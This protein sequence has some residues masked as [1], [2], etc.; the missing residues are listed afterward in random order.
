MIEIVQSALTPV[1]N[2]PGIVEDMNQRLILGIDPCE[3][4]NLRKICI[5]YQHW[6]DFIIVPCFSTSRIFECLEYRL[7]TIGY[8]LK[9]MKDVRLHSSDSKKSNV[10]VF[11]ARICVVDNEPFDVCKIRDKLLSAQQVLCAVALN[12]Y[13]ATCFDS[14]LPNLS[15]G[16]GWCSKNQLPYLCTDLC[17]KT[18]Y[19][20]N[21]LPLSKVPIRSTMLCYQ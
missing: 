3:I 1:A 2:Y 13:L 9:V 7:R 17:T 4:S 18:V 6:D 5:G 14:L 11:A 12:P 20:L 21:G 19:I 8:D 15:L 16:K 10:D